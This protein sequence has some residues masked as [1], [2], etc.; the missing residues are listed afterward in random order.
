MRMQNVQH[1]ALRGSLL[2]LCRDPSIWVCLKIVY[3][4]FQWK[5]TIESSPLKLL[6]VGIPYFQTNPYPFHEV[7]C[8]FSSFQ[9][10]LASER[11][12]KLCFF[13]LDQDNQK[14][15]RGQPFD[16]LASHVQNL[17]TISAVSEILPRAV[18][19]I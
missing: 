14:L 2:F 7:S 12:D 3:L 18:E 17:D 6:F 10:P 9:S 19:Q 1:S 15:I 11:I 16:L 5:I 8:V 4:I 13:R